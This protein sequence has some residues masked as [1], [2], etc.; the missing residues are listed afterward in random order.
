M[1]NKLVKGF[2]WLTIGAVV[3][4]LLGGIYKIVL[5]RV[6]GGE[7]F[8][9]YQQ[10]F[11][12][13]TFLV[14]LITSG[15]P[16]GVSKLLSRKTTQEDKLKTTKLTLS[17][18]FI[19]SLVIGLGMFF[20]ADL[21]ANAQGNSC[22]VVCYYILAP[23]I[24]FSGIAGVLKG[25]FQSFEDFKPTAISQVAE[26]LTKAIL[27]LGLSLIFADKGVAF[28]I[29][30][31]I[32]GVALGDLATLVVLVISF[33][34][35][36]EKLPRLEFNKKDVKELFKTI[37]PIMLSS[38]IIPLS[39]FIDS[40]LVVKLL[41]RNFNSS[42]STYLYGLQSG[43][44]STLISFPSVITFSL[45]SVMLPTLTRDFQS[46]NEE[47]YSNKVSFAIKLILILVIPCAIFALFY[48]NEIIGLLYSN[49]LNGFNVNGVELTSKLLFWSAFN[50]VF[51][52]FSQFLS[53]CLQAREKRYLP[54][55]N[56]TVGMLVKLVLEIVFVP[57]TALNIMSYTLA[58]SV[59]YFVIFFLNFYELKSEVKIKIE[60]QFWVKLTT[61]NI[62]VLISSLC[63]MLIGNSSYKFLI[64]GIF[65]VVI[66]LTL[67]VVLKI[68]SKTDIKKYLKSEK[69]S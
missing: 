69:R 57:S 28:Q 54:A 67:L 58:S 31:A 61:V 55:I 34:R 35:K 1:K 41:N 63:F 16:L 36:K 6:L 23:A 60:Y 8:G 14:V 56:N 38:L 50:I 47:N 64:V 5:T 3:A 43:V 15:V 51:L 25:F 45:V 39:Q 32:L 49:R 29:S 10:I 22:F 42:M 33:K 18:F 9:V 2:T 65:S 13:Y 19:I 37:F 68:F 4:K 62:V 24:V 20:F 40:I 27:G 26:Q 30:M 11:P 17:I 46:K 44:V 66:Y 53:I 59:G 52:C 12:V 48:P 7:S 21:I